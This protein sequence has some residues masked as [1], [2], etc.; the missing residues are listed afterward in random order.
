MKLVQGCEKIVPV[1]QSFWG[2]LKFLRMIDLCGCEGEVWERVECHR[3]FSL[4]AICSA[5]L[6]I[7]LPGAVVARF[8]RDKNIDSFS[9]LQIKRQI[10]NS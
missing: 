4:C 7:N 1:S 3:Y 8:K 5:G 2:D 6:S 10:W 9:G